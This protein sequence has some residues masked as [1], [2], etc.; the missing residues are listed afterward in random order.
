MG[1]KT[2]STCHWWFN[3]LGV[4]PGIGVCVF[5]TGMQNQKIPARKVSFGGTKS[6]KTVPDF[7]CTCWEENRK[8]EKPDA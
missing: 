3:G 5:H 4:T 6:L 1:E 8:K 7:G 2:C